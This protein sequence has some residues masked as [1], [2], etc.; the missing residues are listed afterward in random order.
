MFLRRERKPLKVGTRTYVSLAHSV[1]ER[2]EGKAPR[3][4]PIVLMNLGREDEL[5]L[6]MV[7]D[8]IGVL[9][10]YVD[11]R[12]A[13]EKGAAPIEVAKAVA[14]EVGPKASGLRKLCTLE[15]G[16]RPLLEAVWRDLKLGPTLRLFQRDHKV[17]F[18]FERVIFGL[19]WNRLID[20][21]SKRAANEW[22]KQEAYF[23]EGEGLELQ[24]FYRALDILEQHGVEIQARIL[25]A[26]SVS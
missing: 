6:P 4:K 9:R 14:K 22:L 23:P 13:A 7:E 8:M 1:T 12:L 20:P 21:R 16:L 17:K 26:L 11:E 25:E 2:P 19:V 18:A 15:L 24:H 3:T 10:R 5:D